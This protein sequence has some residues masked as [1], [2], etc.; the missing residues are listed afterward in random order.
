[1]STPSAYIASVLESNSFGVIGTDIFATTDLPYKPD[2]MVIILDP[3]GFSR[4]VPN[5]RYT[6]CRIQINVRGT[7]GGAQDAFDRAEKINYFLQYWHGHVWNTRFV[8]INNVSGSPAYIGLDEGM[9]PIF[10]LNFEA[11]KTYNTY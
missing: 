9:R 7:E 6:M 4:D 2:A 10:S 8:Y 3:P 11:M 1:M 5:L